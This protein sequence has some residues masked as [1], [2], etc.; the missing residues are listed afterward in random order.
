MIAA[1][2]GNAWRIAALGFFA[3]FVAQ[4]LRLADAR[5]DR[6]QAV[7][8]LATERASAERSARQV[9]EKY[10]SLEKDYRESLDKIAA[11]G[12]EGIER[13]HADAGRARAARDSMQRELANYI[14]AHR[15][16]ALARAAAGQ[17]TPDPAPLDLLADLQRRADD[18]AGELAHTADDAR[19]R[20]IACERIY[21]SAREMIEAARNAQAR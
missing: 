11:V 5:R 17:C 3:L 10:R 21:D 4:S 14:D 9:S 7:A 8:S 19:V 13:A 12:N 20:G 6:A 2:T 18:R 15:R 1:I 16:A